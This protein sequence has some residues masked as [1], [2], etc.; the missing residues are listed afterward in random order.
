M[1]HY[2]RGHQTQVHLM[3]DF[4][5]GSGRRGLKPTSTV[6]I[7]CRD[8]L[9]QDEPSD[10]TPSYFRALRDQILH[11]LFP[12]NAFTRKLRTFWENKWRRTLV[13]WCSVAWLSAFIHLSQLVQL[14]KG[15]FGIG[16][17]YES[18]DLSD[19]SNRRLKWLLFF[20]IVAT[21]MLTS[22]NYS[23]QCLGSPTRDDLDKWHRKGKSMAIG[24]YSLS[25]LLRIP[26]PRKILWV[27]LA[28]S[29]LPLNVLYVY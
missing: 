10:Q 21:L 27:L 25:N 6:H 14:P 26:W 11:V 12:D 23:M 15:D 7:G 17:L 8:D 5:P 24:R 1:T 16:I 22:S 29:G 4:L 28:V 13:I 20:N 2:S 18:T 3:E 19:V 9:Y